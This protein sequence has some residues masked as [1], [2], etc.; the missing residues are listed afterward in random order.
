MPQFH[1]PHRRNDHHGRRNH[2][3]TCDEQG[4]LWVN[5]YHG[6]RALDFQA[7]KGLL[8]QISGLESS[9]MNLSNCCVPVIRTNASD[10]YDI[11][12]KS[13]IPSTTIPLTRSIITGQVTSTVPIANNVGSSLTFRNMDLINTPNGFGAYFMPSQISA[14]GLSN[15]LITQSL[16]VTGTLISPF[17]YQSPFTI[18]S[19]IT[20][21]D[22]LTGLFKIN[23][24]SSTFGDPTLTGG[25]TSSYFPK[26]FIASNS[27]K[28]FLLGR[29]TIQITQLPIFEF[30]YVNG[31][32]INNGTAIGADKYTLSIIA[33]LEVSI[34]SDHLFDLL[35]C[36]NQCHE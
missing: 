16:S 34:S 12:S 15:I 17:N 25:E 24:I 13:D 7:H 30:Q 11:I 28:T 2:C 33:P 20:I 36:Q 19:Q 6:H 22:T 10:V 35:T 29:Y 26:F 31:S 32:L 3:G 27:S 4:R 23:T 21:T 8:S 9:D 18:T 14:F 1:D 5:G